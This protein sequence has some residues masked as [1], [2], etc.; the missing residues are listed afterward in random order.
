MER[1]KRVWKFLKKLCFWVF[2]IGLFLITTTTVILHIYE[3]DIKQFA[4][5]EINDHLKTNVEVRNMEVSIF[6]DFPN[7]SL[8]FEHVFIADAFEH[9]GSNDTLLFTEEL[10]LHFNVWDILS[11][12]YEVKRASIHHGQINLKTTEDGDV[13]YGIVKETPDTVQ[14]D[15]KFSFL[16][17]LLKVEDVD[18]GLVNRSTNQ[19]YQFKIH[20]ALIRGDFAATQYQLKA[21]GDFHVNKL[22]SS[23]LTLVSDKEASL[24]LAL[25]INTKE[26][27]YLFN[28][29]DLM[30]EEMAFG[31]TG[32]I[33]S[34]EI[35][36]VIEG[37]QIQVEQLITSLIPEDAESQKNY[38]GQGLVNFSGKIEGP[39][40]RTEM[41]SI[42]ANFSVENGAVVEPEN[43]LKIHS[44]NMVGNYANAYKERVEVLDLS[45]FSFVLLNS[46]LKG[47]ATM[48]DFSQPKLSTHAQGDLD[49]GAFHRFF[50]FADVEE[51][52]GHVQLNLAS[53][54]R[55]FDPEYRKDKFEILS[56]NGSITLSK[57]VFKG[58]GD[59]L[60]YTDI[61]GDII[62]KEKDAATKNLSIKTANSDLLLNGAMKNFIPFIDGTGSLGLIAS[63]ESKQIDLNEFL[64]PSNKE[65][66]GP[67]VMF[68]LPNNLNLNIE[69][70][71]SKFLWDNHTFTDI[72]GQFLMANR[73]VTVNRMHLNTLGGN[74]RGKL[75]LN[76]LLAKGNVVDGKVSFNNINVKA[77]FAEWD[78]FQQESITDKHLSGIVAGNVDFLL[79][80]NPYFSIIEEQILAISDITIKNGELNDMETMKS[81]TDYMRSN[82][83]L[84]VMLNKHIDRFEEKLMHLRFSELHNKIEIKDRRINIPKMTIKSNAMD[85]DLFGW[86]DF[87]NNIEYHFSFRF[88]QLKT[89][90]EYTEFGKIEDDGLGIVIYMTMAGNLDDPTFSLDKDE[91][92]NDIKESVAEE[93]S[94][95][96]SMLK[97]EFGLF[98]KD[99]TVRRMEEENKNEVEF[100][101][102]ETDIEEEGSIKDT[103]KS[104]KNKKRTNKFFDKMK[105][106]AEKNKQEVEYEEDIEE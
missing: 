44:I 20:H 9:T 29:G 88:R 82:K 39:V 93:K 65:R 80:F 94:T 64:G 12:N 90:P 76:N 26:S 70:H 91:R 104:K 6:H 89:K 48:E 49:L 71:L 84:K 19:D 36:L 40:S 86:H 10:F 75:I 38:Q 74:V 23:S 68:E 35:N 31:V 72:T 32:A 52:S 30:I 85:V 45:A 78:N 28:K 11:G 51:L 81:I 17:D 66:E 58:V 2:F 77:L 67:L 61:S 18:F 47:V 63:L 92:K 42:T 102:Y 98:Q 21:E 59:A 43:N 13:N 105:E 60:R 56:S 27:S 100:I 7:A 1:V 62:V 101:Y 79:I 8:A 3:D 57:V 83:A 95:V 55:F 87:D 4:I 16:L 97:T 99:T 24:D 15:D 46:H 34:S 73:K 106:E 103:T 5:S 33:D 54:I 69:M 96:K 25:D 41:P 22:K 50:G 14:T 37:K 53:T